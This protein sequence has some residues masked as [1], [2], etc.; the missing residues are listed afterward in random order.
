MAKYRVTGGLGRLCQFPKTV[1]VE[2]PNREEAFWEAYR[3]IKELM[4]QEDF[5]GDENS[6]M[7]SKLIGIES[8]KELEELGEE[9][10]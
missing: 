10:A 3:S 7:L 6:P 4:I 9:H 8:I 1:E 2:A 5:K